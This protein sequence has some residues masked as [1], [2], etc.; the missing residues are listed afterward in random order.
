MVALNFDLQLKDVQRRVEAVCVFDPNATPTNVAA[1]GMPTEVQS[2]NPNTR[3]ITV[4]TDAQIRFRMGLHRDLMR[5]TGFYPTWRL[6][7]K[8]E[9]PHFFD[10]EARSL[11]MTNF[12]ETNDERYIEALMMEALPSDRA[13]FQKYL[14]KRPLGL[15]IITAVSHSFVLTINWH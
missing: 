12:L 14:S 2:T 1:Y 15:G 10:H 9:F 8:R 6:E 13:G 5:G 11:P 3:P 4:P 7:A